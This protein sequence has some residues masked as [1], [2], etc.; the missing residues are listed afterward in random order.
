MLH[1]SSYHGLWQ[2]MC[3]DRVIQVIAEGIGYRFRNDCKMQ[4]SVNLMIFYEAQY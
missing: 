3:L 1:V 2:R 4:D